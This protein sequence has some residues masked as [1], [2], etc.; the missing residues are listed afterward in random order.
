LVPLCPDLPLVVPA[1][2]RPSDSC[3]PPWLAVVAEAGAGLAGDCCGQR[4]ATAVAGYLIPEH[5]PRCSQAAKSW[6]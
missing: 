4:V 5:L 3:L 2:G 1:C 6:L